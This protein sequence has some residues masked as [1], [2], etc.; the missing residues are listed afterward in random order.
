MIGMRRGKGGLL[1]SE[2]VTCL[3]AAKIP[4]GAH[5]SETIPLD[6]PT[7]ARHGSA[8]RVEWV[9]NALKG[10]KFTITPQYTAIYSHIIHKKIRYIQDEMVCPIAHSSMLRPMSYQH[11][12]RLVTHPGHQTRSG[13]CEL[14]S[15]WDWWPVAAGRGGPRG[16]GREPGC[17]P[18]RLGNGFVF[19]DGNARTGRGVRGSGRERHQ[20]VPRHGGDATSSG[21]II[22]GRS[23]GDPGTD[24]R[25]SPTRHSQQ[26]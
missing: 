23:G 5:G 8:V 1:A 12:T 20:T 10:H 2:R 26:R 17:V 22:F 6:D 13:T 11:L 19:Q 21:G 24:R 16:S 15:S 7:C 25:G 14:S 9:F 18:S 4:S 3:A